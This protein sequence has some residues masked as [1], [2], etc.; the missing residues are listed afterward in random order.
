MNNQVCRRWKWIVMA[1][2]FLALV[3]DVA[4]AEVHPAAVLSFYERGPGMKGMGAKVGDIL[5]AELAGNPDL[6][7]VER[8]EMDRML[9]EY[10]I[11]LSGMVQSGQA[12][13]VGQ[14][15]GARILVTGSVIEADSVL[16]LVA[17]IIGTETSRVLGASAKGDVSDEIAPL[18]EE[19]AGKIAALVTEKGGELV[20]RRVSA[21]DR[22]KVLREALGDG[23]RPALSIAIT[24]RHVGQAT[25]DP[26]AET[27][28]T[29]YAKGTGFGVVDAETGDERDADIVVKG[30]G[31]SEFGLRRGNLVSVKARVE[32]KAVDRKTDE[33]IAIDRQTAVEVDLAEQVAGKKALQEAASAIAER[34]LPKLAR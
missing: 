30:E 1:L 12:V 7:L 6:F 33:V 18:V 32:I 26:A 19:L 23:E 17:K 25:I 21:E 14:L 20:A 16:Y 5:F 31:F 3:A 2:G 27:E 24:E 4:E 22:I 10:E 11:N 8:S 13:Q 34:M 28:F 9:K 29:L 15:T